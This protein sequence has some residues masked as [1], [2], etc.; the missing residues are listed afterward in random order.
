MF[1]KLAKPY[2]VGRMASA[3]VGRR[4]WSFQGS[5]IGRSV[6]F[7]GFGKKK[8]LYE[9]LEIDKSAD[10]KAVKKAFQKKGMKSAKQS[11]GLPSRCSR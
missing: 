1:C 11:E 10:T 5:R 7:A 3:A 8:T 2:T 6:S 4:H 9:V